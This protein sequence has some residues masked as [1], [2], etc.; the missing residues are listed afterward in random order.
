MPLDDAV[1]IRA[2]DRER[3]VA[4]AANDRAALLA[5]GRAAA[6]VAAALDGAAVLLF[7]VDDRPDHFG[8]LLE[9]VQDARGGLLWYGD[10]LAGSPPATALDAAGGPAVRH[11]D[12]A[13]WTALGEVMTCRAD[14]DRPHLRPVTA[15]DLIP[16]AGPG[17]WVALRVSQ[18]V[19]TAA[20]LLP[21]PA[22]AAALAAARSSV[23]SANEL[24]DH[25][26][27]THTRARAR[28]AALLCSTVLPDAALLVFERDE[29]VASAETTIGLVSARDR[30]GS[31][32]WYDDTH[33]F[34]EHP[35]AQALGDPPTLDHRVLD[36]VRLH[37]VVGYDASPGWFAISD[38]SFGLEP[39]HNLLELDIDALTA[40]NH[41]GGIACGCPDRARSAPVD[42]GYLGGQLD[43]A[44]LE[45]ALITLADLWTGEDPHQVL[46]KTQRRIADRIKTLINGE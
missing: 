18:A 25:A 12:E 15:A 46:T 33:P 17:Q 9:A 20:A 16:E 44:D 32:L 28:M 23:F 7:S 4:T 3:A 36:E 40:P 45:R 34:A 19:R 11:F 43:D 10:Q 37:L 42:A 31:L 14:L 6:L 26:G 29:D 13:A 2:L 21:G 24:A 8:Y 30:A 5:A 39:E 35:D 41:A 22:S 38:D 1:L 27:A